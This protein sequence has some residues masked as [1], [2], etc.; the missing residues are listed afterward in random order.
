MNDAREPRV[1]SW[2]PTNRDDLI[3]DEP[4]GRALA[5][6]DVVQVADNQSVC[7]FAG[8]KKVIF[9]VPRLYTIGYDDRSAAEILKANMLGEQTDGMPL[10]VNT[11]LVFVCRRK[12]EYTVEMPEYIKFSPMVGI[13]PEFRLT[14]RVDNEEE[15]LREMDP[16]RP[17]FDQVMEAV[18]RFLARKLREWIDE[19]GVFDEYTNQE[20]AEAQFGDREWPNSFRHALSEAAKNGRYFGVSIE[21]LEVTQWGLWSGFCDVCGGKVGRRDR[22]CANGHA[23]RR[24]PECSE[25]IYRGNCLAHGHAVLWC[26]ECGEYV[27]PTKDGNCPVHKNIRM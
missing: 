24:C 19:A 7:F 12:R 20:Q 26:S 10:L 5:W 23:L 6:G 15:L 13:R 21:E 25:L 1:F 11:R 2:E 9:E 17:A 4:L 16:G 8:G 27:T 22:R 14:L 3:Y 18:C